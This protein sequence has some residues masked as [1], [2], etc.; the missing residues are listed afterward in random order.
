MNLA[1]L[2]NQVPHLYWHV[3]PR[4]VS[5]SHF[6]GAVLGCPP[7]TRARRNCRPDLHR[8]SRP[9]LA[10][11]DDERRS[12]MTGDTT[13]RNDEAPAQAEGR[14]RSPLWRRA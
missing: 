9:G 4:F 1:S 10:S 12:Q 14:A 13:I 7:A 6:P 2:G 5:D 11:R 3:V 8:R